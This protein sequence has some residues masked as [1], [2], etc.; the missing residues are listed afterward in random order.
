M[1]CVGAVRTAE[2]E[3][4]RSEAGRPDIPGYVA[5]LADTSEGR[6][7]FVVSGPDGLN[8]T[9]RNAC[10]EAVKLGADIQLRVEKF[11]W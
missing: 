2:A 7:G 8:R 10:A 11:G 9:A 1:Y 3:G 5:D 6:V 4:T